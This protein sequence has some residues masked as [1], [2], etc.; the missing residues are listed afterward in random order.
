MDVLQP[1]YTQI[2]HKPV[3]RSVA[4]HEQ[5][6]APSGVALSSF[7]AKNSSQHSRIYQTRGIAVYATLIVDRSTT[8][9]F[10]CNDMASEASLAFSSLNADRG[11]PTIFFI[12]GAFS[13]GDGWSLVTPHLPA[14][15]LLLPD[16]PGHGRAKSAALPFSVD[17]C[18]SLL[19][20]CIERHAEGG[21]AH[22]VGI[23]LG[24][25]L[26]LALMSTRPDIVLTAF[27]SGYNRFPSASPSTVYWAMRAD[28]TAQRLIPRSLSKWL[29]DGAE[30]PETSA[31]PSD[32]LLRAV[33]G[34][35]SST[36]P[37]S[38]S[39]RTLVVVAGKQGLLP[40]ADQGWAAIKLK[41]IGLA[42]GAECRA[43]RHPMMRHPWDRQDGPLF[44][45]AVEA[46]VDKGEVVEGFVEIDDAEADGH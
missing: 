10:S 36:W 27:I 18:V 17:L 1:L 5:K 41:R 20:D 37:E 3:S 8:R 35:E 7:T 23:S 28:Q 29:M 34:A 6:Q 13:S 26:A 12:H 39:A 43:V 9:L 14:F 33:A 4:V 44:A 2:A 11:L 40:T 19:A 30:S 32:A 22:I 42:G 21:K 24:A 38:W 45:R 46:W 25:T 31:P 15:H 16:L